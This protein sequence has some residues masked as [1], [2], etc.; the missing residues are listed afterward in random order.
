MEL[1]KAFPELSEILCEYLS[2]E[3]TAEIDRYAWYIYD[4]ESKV[5]KLKFKVPELKA[6][7]LEKKIS[8]NE[9]TES[10]YWAITN[11]DC[12]GSGELSRR[13]SME[14]YA[15]FNHIKVLAYV[16]GI[17]TLDEFIDFTILDCNSV[18]EEDISFLPLFRDYVRHLYNM[19]V[20]LGIV[21]PLDPE[22]FSKRYF[23]PKNN[24]PYFDIHQE[25]KTYDEA[26]KWQRY[27][28]P[29]YT[30]AGYRSSYS[31]YDDFMMKS[32]IEGKY[33]IPQ[34][35]QIVNDTI[36]CNGI[37][38]LEVLLYDV[39]FNLYRNKEF[40]RPDG[41]EIE[42]RAQDLRNH[43]RSVP[44]VNYPDYKL[45]HRKEHYKKPIKTYNYDLLFP[46]IVAKV[47]Y[48]IAF[49]DMIFT[50]L[51]LVYE[52]HNIQLTIAS[53]HKE[54]PLNSQS[55]PPPI[56]PRLSIR[57]IA[58]IKIYE[59]VSVTRENGTEL[60]GKYG[61]KSGGRLYNLFLKFSHRSER[62]GDEG[63]K[64]KNAN[65]RAIFE[66]VIKELENDPKALQWAVDEFNMF[67][68]TAGID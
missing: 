26:W 15:L 39:E 51:P 63:T 55:Q 5:N 59:K 48:L 6:A 50:R 57:E 2:I 18:V 9:I 68:A 42:Y 19:E 22:G 30:P 54:Q 56:K 31:V 41:D 14:A 4:K 49:R 12:S 43:E 53:E 1:K 45:K 47:H 62:V 24:E 46:E 34:L 37:I 65:K 8:A 23:T 33:S 64:K 29:S 7:I 44:Y 66:T 60:V 58:W 67:K 32:V 52:K 10:I 21:V 35:Q 3:T 38:G 28:L 36:L 20:I 27:S 11:F 40:L 61:H 16:K 17:I 13:M 25:V